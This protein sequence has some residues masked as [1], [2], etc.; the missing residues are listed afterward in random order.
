MR[1]RI[2]RW[3]TPRRRRRFWIGVVVVSALVLAATVGLRFASTVKGPETGAIVDLWLPADASPA[4]LADVLHEKGLVGNKTVTAAYLRAMTDPSDLV[5]GRHILK[6][7]LS[8][9]DLI[10]VLGRKEGRPTVKITFPEGLHRFAMADRL[11]AA[12]IVP[13]DAFLQATADAEG[14][15]F[16]ATYVFPL[17]AET[18]NVVATLKAEADRRW[19]NLEDA[20]EDGLVDLKKTL[21][22]GRH[23]IVILASMVEKEAAVDAERPTIASVFLN[24]LQDPSFVP[25]KLQSDPT[26]AYACFVEPEK[27]PA[28]ADFSGKI[29]PKL[30]NDPQNRY[31]T[32]VREGLP[33]G[34]VANP[35]ERAIA[36]V[37]A[38]AQTRYFY[39][40]AAGGR[41]H[42]FSETL[43]EHNR[44][45]REGRQ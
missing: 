44:A 22:F 8:L 16:P 14:Y 43:E 31:S 23:E 21:G 27:V 12:A 41:K 35:G 38:P 45:I 34:P 40:V 18:A 26:S 3:L 32:Y 5:P 10:D 17:N 37:L 39:F 11:Q 24:R 15:L 30:N 20:H 28:C 19:R 2:R 33:P 9:R 4:E 36:A 25:H 1:D 7:G 29:T 42:R 6:S 13:K